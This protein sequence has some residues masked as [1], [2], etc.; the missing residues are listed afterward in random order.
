MK[1]FYIAESSTSY[2][3]IFFFLLF[4]LSSLS[5]GAQAN[6]YGVITDDEQQPVAFA[7]VLLLSSADSSLIKGAVTNE[8]GTYQ[9]EN[10]IAGSYLLSASMISYGTVYSQSTIVVGNGVDRIDAPVLMLGDGAAM[11]D[12]VEVKARKPLFEQKIDRMVVNVA[13]SITSAGGTALDILERAPG[14]NVN[15]QTNAISM[16]GKNGVLVMI[17]GKE[18]RMP[19]SALVQMLGGMNSDN[20]EKI[21]LITTPPASFDAEGDAGII[22]IILKK[23]IDEGFNGS[24]SLNVGYARKEKTSNSISFN[25]R[26]DKINWYGDYAFLR[27]NSLQL[28]TNDRRVVQ[29]GNTIDINSDSNRDPYQYN[30]NVRLGLDW[31]LSSKTILG[32]LASGYNNKWTM[33]AVNDVSTF[34]NG[35]PTAYLEVINDE[36]NHWKHLMGNVNLQHNFSKNE[37]LSVNLDYLYFHDNN[38]TN[39]LNRSFDIDDGSILSEEQVRSGKITPLNFR[40]GKADYKKTLNDKVKMEAGIKGALNRFDNEVNVDYLINDSW[41]PDAELTQ[42]YDL[43]ED[44]LAAYTSWSFKLSEKTS[45][46]TGLRFEHTRSLLNS[47]EQ[48]RIVDRKYGEWF[49]TVYIGHDINDNNRIQIAYNRRIS[50]PTFRDLAPFVI[51]ID[52]STFYTGNAAIQPSFTNAVKLDYRWK[53]ILTSIEYNNNQSFI[54]RYQ[55]IV[56]L[57]ENRQLVTAVNLDQVQSVVLSLTL[58]WEPTTWWNIQNSFTGFWTEIDS[59][60]DGEQVKQERK[61]WTANSAHNFTLPKD[62]TMEVSFRYSSPRIFGISTTN[63]LWSMNVGVQKKFAKEWGTLRAGIRDVFNT[64]STFKSTAFLPDLGID[65]HRSYQFSWRRF[66]LTYSRNFGNKKIKGARNRQTG[67]EDERRRVN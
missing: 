18:N 9:I 34:E 55:P 29:N 50:R 2:L 11:L 46:Q 21:E 67:S 51:F 63:A 45:L 42:T 56:D 28:F 64:S 31:E 54:A 13:N 66:D 25:Y 41:I 1:N 15:R 58:P 30:H 47:L 22:N 60:Y 33:D 57:E 4:I 5:L 49:P 65:I 6:I 19:L 3:S 53:T 7:N 43:E 23:N 61:T 38:P 17:N 48:P 36:I 24:I 35:E 12:E 8:A 27:E 10:V 40:V 37:Q 20:I 59:K 26:K 39:Y 14:V 62:F 44:I 16:S 52:P 32:I